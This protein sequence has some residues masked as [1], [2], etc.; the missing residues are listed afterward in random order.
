MRTTLPI[1]IGRVPLNGTADLT[2]CLCGAKAT[3]TGADL[4]TAILEHGWS[5]LVLVMPKGESMSPI[6]PISS[7][8]LQ[9]S[10]ERG[11]AS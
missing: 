11:G 4:A 8:N 5:L 10:I 9:R 3:V 2:C 6:C 1:G 7:A